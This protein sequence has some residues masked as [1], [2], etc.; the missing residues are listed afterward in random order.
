MEVCIRLFARRRSAPNNQTHVFSRYTPRPRLNGT[1]EEPDGGIVLSIPMYFDNQQYRTFF[2][3]SVTH[4]LLSPD[5]RAG[6][7]AFF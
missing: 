3:T 1:P 7:G 6:A 4:A 5:P 2:L